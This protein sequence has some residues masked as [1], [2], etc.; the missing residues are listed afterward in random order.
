MA[1]IE[2]CFAFEHNLSLVAAAAAVCVFG[3]WVLLG[4]IGR[5]KQAQGMQRLGWET[6]A[7]TSAGASIWCTHFVAILAYQPG[8]PIGF[9]PMLTVASALVA[10]LGAFV[11]FV[12]ALGGRW[13]GQALLGGA[14]LGVAIS[15]MHYCGMLAYRV[16]GIVAWNL[17]TLI[18]SIAVAMGFGAAGLHLAVH[19]QRGRAQAY[20]L[21]CLTAAIIGLHFT[22][23]AALRIIA[24]R[25]EVT[26][27]NGMALHALALAILGMTMI[28]IGA[29]VVTYLIDQDI[30]ADAYKR[31]RA[32][33]LRDPL[34][35]LPNR[36]YLRAHLERQIEDAAIMRG[37]V[38]LVTIDLNG[39][40]YVNDQ[41]GHFAGDVVLKR[42]AERLR[43]AL[44]PQEFG[45]CLGGD[46]FAVAHLVE[47]DN[48][49]AGLVERLTAI[50]A[51]PV[52]AQ[53][54]ETQINASFGIAEFPRDGGGVEAL[55]NNAFLALQRAKADHN[56]PVCPYDPT[57]GERVRARR[58]M[59]SDLRAAI[60]KG[61]LEVHYQ[62]QTAVEGGAIQGFEA[63]ARWPRESGYTPPAE[64]IP[65]AEEYGL[66]DALGLWV[67][68]TACR[69]AALWANPVKIAV[70]LSPLQLTDT[71]FPH[72]VAAVLAET[73]LPPSRLELEL[74]ESAIIREAR[75]SLRAMRKIRELGVSLALDDFGTGHSSLSTLRMFPIDKIK[76]D[77]SFLWEIETS[78]QAMAVLRAVLALG[79]GLGIP[80][81]TEGVET[82]GQLEMLRAEGCSQAQGYL[83]GKPTSMRGLIAQGRLWLATPQADREAAAA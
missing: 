29:G 43:G 60:D 13:R 27:T 76:L 48:S 79:N 32:M 83:L 70:N 51:A 38:A 57:M 73:G 23:M 40:K 11:A 22:G 6:L 49:L 72:T 52:Q 42:V 30:R 35:G 78:P 1:S 81:L 68:R 65:V 66:I 46:E 26:A 63:L 47:D 44:R 9:D 17:P 19:G 3:S 14:L 55:F 54:F 67:L 5:A 8:V 36:S 2:S 21:A 24:L 69:E 82:E 18:A 77:R 10:S 61:E 25:F 4:L 37:R 56:A 12:V 31:M 50:F 53:D 74:T 16:E 20:A 62:V 71:Q 75:A 7:A 58:Q 45:A 41:Y 59:A 64:F 28:I 33:S 80:V 34:T 39:F 15:A